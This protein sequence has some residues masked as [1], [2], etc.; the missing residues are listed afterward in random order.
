MISSMQPASQTEG[1]EM[2]SWFFVTLYGQISKTFFGVYRDFWVVKAIER[3]TN[4]KFDLWEPVG[5]EKIKLPVCQPWDG[6]DNPKIKVR[7][8]KKVALWPYNVTGNF[9]AFLVNLTLFWNFF[10]QAKSVI[11]KNNFCRAFQICF[12]IKNRI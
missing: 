7:H 11:T 1:T 5:L 4:R 10:N 2:R 12:W 6:L 3:L 8:Q 9:V